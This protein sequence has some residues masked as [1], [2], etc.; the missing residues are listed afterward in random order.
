[1]V[2]TTSAEQL[3][4]YEAEHLDDISRSFAVQHARELGYV[5]GQGELFL[6]DRFQAKYFA[7]LRDEN[8]DK[9]VIPRRIMERFRFNA[10][11]AASGL[12]EDEIANS[13]WTAMWDMVLEY[14]RA[15]IMDEKAY[16]GAEDAYVLTEQVAADVFA[17]DY[18][19]I[20]EDR[21]TGFALIIV[22]GDE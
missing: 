21:M 6:A 2:S 14:R 13:S 18:K 9:L 16:H 8:P 20:A 19:Q 15:R 17:A 11:T 3:A 5:L 7:E 4:E 12:T 10:G 1:M 22:E